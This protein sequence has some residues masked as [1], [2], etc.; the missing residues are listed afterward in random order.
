MNEGGALADGDR[1]LETIKPVPLNH[2]LAS[3]PEP[4]A[5]PEFLIGALD[6]VP[7]D[8]GLPFHKDSGYS[9]TLK[10]IARKDC[11]GATSYRD[12]RR[13][14]SGTG[15]FVVSDDRAANASR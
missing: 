3:F 13:H 4:D 14:A 8:N 12:E 7:M 2:R 6:L 15:E 10:G 1:L 9:P 11:L 5:L